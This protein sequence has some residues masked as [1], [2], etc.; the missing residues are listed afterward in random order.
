MG[1]LWMAWEKK[2][3][4]II[5]LRCI[6]DKNLLP[7]RLATENDENDVFSFHHQKVSVPL[8]TGLH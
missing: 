4:N 6:V 5:L 8:W 1:N 7:V 2:K 3:M